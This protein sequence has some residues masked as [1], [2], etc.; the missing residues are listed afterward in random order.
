MDVDGE[1][2][3]MVVSKHGLVS[4]TAASSS[5]LVLTGVKNELCVVFDVETGA[6]E[7][8]KPRA[9]LNLVIALDVSG[10]MRAEQKLKKC[11]LAIVEVI[12]VMGS[13]DRLSLCTYDTNVKTIF[14]GQTV[15][16]AENQLVQKVMALRAGSCTNLW[17]GLERA[18]ELVKEFATTDSENW[19]MLFSDGVVNAGE[20]KTN[21]AIT[22]NMH[23][24]ICAPLKCKVSAFGV[25][26]S[27]NE[28]LM[29]AVA[30]VGLGIYFF[31]ESSDSIVDFV[32]KAL[33]RLLNPACHD[34]VL[35]VQ[36]IGGAVVTKM[37][38]HKDI[39]KGAQLGDL[40][41]SNTRSVVV[42][43]EYTPS[44]AE[45]GTR[46]EILSYSLSFRPVGEAD[47]VV[48]KE[49]IQVQYSNDSE[50]VEA[51]RSAD[52]EARHL[53]A[54]SSDID[55]KVA[56]CLENNDVAGA[57]TWQ[58]EN[59]AVLEQ[60][61]ARDVK[62]KAQ[63]AAMYRDAQRNMRSIETEG[64]SSKNKKTFTSRGYAKRRCSASYTAQMMD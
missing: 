63:A 14:A 32:S 57:R 17:G 23:D 64:A 28:T 47:Q 42:E 44:G 58:T 30:E 53:V 36:G 12:K 8:E 37:Y 39:V 19:I 1:G 56:E 46:H 22:D 62:G 49:T 33:S 60:A 26:T 51:S 48:L 52:V 50:K 7:N 43:L 45:P 38:G 5:P 34:S 24:K 54:K 4:L 61:V 13:R 35:K 59:F 6:A 18:G 15:G 10:S 20:F 2:D 21:E 41:Q 16:Q 55:S 40:H 3:H 11:Q 31:I 9:P 27:F 29:E 25:G